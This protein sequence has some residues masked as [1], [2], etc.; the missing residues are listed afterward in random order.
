MIVITMVP[1]YLKKLVGE[2]WNFK[3]TTHFIM[4]SKINLWKYPCLQA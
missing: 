3:I 4:S 2:R 1:I